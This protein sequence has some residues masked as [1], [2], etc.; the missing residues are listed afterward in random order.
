MPGQLFVISGPSGAGKSSIV[1][2]LL[3]RT[4]GLVYSISHTS[5]RPRGTEK[6]GIDYHFVDSVTFSRMIE[7]GA[8]VEWAKVY[9]DFYGTSF[10]SL[11]GQTGSGLDVLLDVDSQGARNIRK[12]FE[13]SVL[14]YVLPPSLK[15]LEKRLK[16]RGTDDEGVINARMERAALEVRNFEWYDYVIINDDLKKAITEARAIIISERCRIARQASAQIL[17]DTFRK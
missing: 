5:R 11:E 14:I 12:H 6:D 1:N 16:G 3:G 15:I 10:S 8:F 17:L 9:D 13:D 2:A 7:A 4:D